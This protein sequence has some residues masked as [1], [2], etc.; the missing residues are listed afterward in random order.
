MPL[1]L[2]P[3]FA[4]TCI[5]AA[6]V[7]TTTGLPALAHSTSAE[8]SPTELAVA[9]ADV[10]QAA[11]ERIRIPRDVGV[12]EEGDDWNTTMSSASE[13]EVV[14]FKGQNRK[15]SRGQNA[16]NK[17]SSADSTGGAQSPLKDHRV[18]PSTPEGPA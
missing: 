15:I 18:A 9:L 13:E 10:N 7:I 1:P 14:V 4:A 2:P 6:L 5:A 3:H 16:I 11:A 12:A 8:S 17:S